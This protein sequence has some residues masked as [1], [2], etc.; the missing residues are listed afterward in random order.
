MKP[1]DLADLLLLAALWG[2]SFLF[3]RV[4]APEFGPLALIEMRVGIASL[5]LVGLVALRRPAAFTALA[6]EAR[7]IALVGVLNSA[8]PFVLFAWAM[9][10]LT[11][12]VASVLN[13]T[14][15]LFGA[16]VAWAWLG[17]RLSRA[18]V[19]GLALGFVGVGV[20]VWGRGDAGAAGSVW[21]AVAAALAASLSYGVSASYTKRRLTGV[22]PLAL[23]TGTQLA[24]A[25]LLAPLALVAWPARPPS[26]LAW[27]CAV[28]LA[29]AS[30]GIAYVIFFRLIARVGPARA[31]TVT[32]LVPVFGVFWGWLALGETPTAGMALGAAVVL[33]GTALA[34]G[35]VGGGGR[36]GATSAAGP[37]DVVDGGQSVVPVRAP[38]GPGV[39]APTATPGKP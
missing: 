16:L 3:M 5:F 6:R 26:A 33:A 10:S 11:A 13:A 17:D 28:L 36:A 18:R 19:A 27:G 9:L 39:A 30:T 22:D 12:G 35:I 34:T 21:P 31:I 14:T 37:A 23:A 2:G 25:L 32:F 20:L 1:R 7:A 8:L 15:P 4:A 24:A 38:G 29:I